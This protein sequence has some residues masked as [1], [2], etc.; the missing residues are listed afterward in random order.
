MDKLLGKRKKYSTFYERARSQVG[1]GAGHRTRAIRGHEGRKVPPAA[2]GA[3]DIMDAG[4][5]ELH[6]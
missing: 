6:L 5:I 2:I 1:D 4:P 3:M